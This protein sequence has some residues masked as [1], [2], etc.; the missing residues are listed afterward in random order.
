MIIADLIGLIALAA[1]FGGGM[2]GFLLGKL[3]PESHRNAPT[4]RIVGTA[5]G[6]ISLLSA[7]VLGLLVAT[8][9]G[10]FDTNN[11]QVE[12]FAAN[13]MLL[14]SELVSYGPE[15][16]D[17]KLLLKKYVIANI[18]ATWQLEGGPRPEPDDPPPLQLLQNMQLGILGLTPQSDYQRAMA[19]SASEITAE[20]IKERWFQTAQESGHAPRPFLWILM[21]W[22]TVLFVGFGLFA[23]R[24]AVAVAAL[25]VSALSIAGAIALIEDMDTPFGGIIVVSPAPVQEALDKIIAPHRQHPV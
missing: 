9:K 4:E 3:L 11:S 16:E 20:I 23:P 12:K 13:L 21:A 15:T 10:K 5:M 17:I 7:L 2:L 22:I 6:T 19:R 18:A 8:A 24:N 1:I 25:V 14:H